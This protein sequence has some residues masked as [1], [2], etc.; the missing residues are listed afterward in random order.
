VS[1]LAVRRHFVACVQTHLFITTVALT[2]Q[3]AY[4]L[5]R[6]LNKS[7]ATIARS[8]L[9]RFLEVFEDKLN[10]SGVSRER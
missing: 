5:V 3:R 7:N 4:Y 8:L 6:V 10:W 2:S 9:V 1:A